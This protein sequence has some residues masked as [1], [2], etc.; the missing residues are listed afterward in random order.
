MPYT[1]VPAVSAGDWIDEVFINTYWVDNMAASVPDL[2]SARGQLAVGLGVDTMG[3]LNAGADGTVLMADSAEPLGM[4]WALAGAMYFIAEQVL[5]AD[6]PSVTFS[7][8]PSI[9]TDLVVK[10]DTRVNSTSAGELMLRCNGDSGNNY[11]YSWS[12]LSNFNLTGD[13]LTGQNSLQG[14]VVT[15][16][17]C[18]ANAFGAGDITIPRYASRSHYLTTYGFGSRYFTGTFAYKMWTAGQWRSSAPVDTLLL[19]GKRGDLRSGSRFALYG[20]K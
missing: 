1:P 14:A 20:I 17:A 10:Y 9:Y 16:N 8:I 12:F 15:D 7:S 3:I 2:F 5:N 6:A 11:D 13:H 19:Y 4:K 18:D